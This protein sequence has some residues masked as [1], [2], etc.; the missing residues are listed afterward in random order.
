[1]TGTIVDLL[2]WVCTLGCAL[3]AGLYFA[4]STFIMAA[5]GRIPAPAG[6]AAMQAINAVI[7]RSL[8][9]PLFFGSTLASLV[10][11]ALSLWRWAE[12]GAAMMLAGGL[13]YFVGMF[14]CTVVFNVPLNNRLDAADPQSEA[15]RDTWTR[16]LRVWTRWNHV[17]TLASTAA[18]GLFVL[19]LVLR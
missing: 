7:Q 19:A 12:P 5:L 18:A 3:I 4:F 15:A 13:V 10:A 1:M 17:R 16:Y 2:L 8:F 9:M 14:V 6:I 11:V